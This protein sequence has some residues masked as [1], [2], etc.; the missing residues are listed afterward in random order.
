MPH[1]FPSVDASHAGLR[2]APNP[3]RRSAA[4]LVAE[5]AAHHQAGRLAEA[6]Q[7]YRKVLAEE[8]RNPDA[9]HGLGLLATQANRLLDAISLLRAAIE[10]DSR[11]PV[12]F[13]N[14]GNAL[15]LH[16]HAESAIAAYT[17]ALDLS[18]NSS[19]VYCNLG[20]A[21]LS[22]GRGEEAVRHLQTAAI[23]LKDAA[24]GSSQSA[25]QVHDNLGNALQFLGSI[26]QLEEAV[27]HHRRALHLAAGSSSHTPEMLGN[28]GLAFAAL[29][30]WAEAMESFD[31]SLS[32]RPQNPRIQLARA[33]L[34]LLLGDFDPGLRN[35]EARKQLHRPRA[36]PGKS[37]RGEHIQPGETLLLYAEQ[38]LGDT[39][40]TLRYLSWVRARIATGATLIAEV[41]P[42]LLRL[43]QTLPELA[44]SQMRSQ[45]RIPIELLAQGEPLPQ[46][47]WHCSWMSLSLVCFET[48]GIR[49]TSEPS[50]QGHTSSA[51][52]FPRTSFP[53]LFAPPHDSQILPPLQFDPAQSRVL[54]I[55]LVWSGNKSHLRDKFRSIP[56]AL[57]QPLLAVEGCRFHSLQIEEIPPG[58][59]HRVTDHR[60]AQTDLAD[61]A[62]LI[63]QLDLVISVDTAIAHLA[64]ALAKPV[65]LMLPFWPDWRW[66]LDRQDCP[67]YPTIHLFRQHKPGAWPEVIE[68]VRTA[69]LHRTQGSARSL[70]PL[71]NLP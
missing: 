35:Y 63:Q 48:S 64:G 45:M 36:L 4:D 37:W 8:Q 24:H 5:A 27:K 66:G 60:H 42:P 6:E 70:D 50:G 19:T 46:T 57:L 30:K 2:S 62:R 31:R 10:A 43:A 28:L 38:G 71:S 1:P 15:Q 7:L 26:A 58:F 51:T 17:Q 14:L 34:Q 47:D 53:Y 69:L 29:G 13:L 12:Y 20:M 18:P 3:V 54:E 23:L 22:L 52:P 67:W 41:Q 40:Q 16:G 21:L 9:L 39:I 65:W 68:T 59:A 61:T 56:P 44:R 32:R 33:Q 49:E 11:Q 55:G 25:A